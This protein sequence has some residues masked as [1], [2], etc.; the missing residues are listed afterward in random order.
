MISTDTLLSR[1]V[2]RFSTVTKAG[3]RIRLPASSLDRNRRPQR[4]KCWV[5]RVLKLDLCLGFHFRFQHQYREHHH[6]LHIVEVDLR[7]AVGRGWD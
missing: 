4:H 5:R 6:R 2:P 7:L 3:W 1:S